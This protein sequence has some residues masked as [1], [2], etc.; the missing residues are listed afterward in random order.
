[1]LASIYHTYMDPSWVGKQNGMVIGSTDGPVE[2]EVMLDTKGTAGD[3]S[4]GLWLLVK[5]L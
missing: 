4:Y 1:M 2:L 5:M 3:V